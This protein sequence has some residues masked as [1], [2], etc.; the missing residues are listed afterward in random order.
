MEY[1]GIY[2]NNG[3]YE[4]F[5]PTDIWDIKDI[6]TENRIQLTKEQWLEGVTLD[7]RVINGVHTVIET[8]QEELDDR[9]YAILRENRNKLLAESDWTQ[10]PDSPLTDAQKQAW[11]T[12]R[13]SLRDLPDTVDINNIVYPEKP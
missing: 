1:F 2:N 5:Y 10:M 12:Y 11:A 9:A 13:Q 4:G 6:P 7:C 8:T 3:E